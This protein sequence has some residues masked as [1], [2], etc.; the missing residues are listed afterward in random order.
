MRTVNR[1]ARVLSLALLL[2]I[3]AAAAR[4][5]SISAGDSASPV[6][7]I[8]IS[9]FNQ[10]VQSGQLTVPS[11]AVLNHDVVATF[12]QEHP[13][14]PGFA[15]LVEGIPEPQVPGWNYAGYAPD[16]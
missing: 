12:M 15:Q 4:A 10:M 8:D 3:S 11:L 1:A 13:N 6:Q 5:Q 7:S 14:L 2:T 9:R 16:R